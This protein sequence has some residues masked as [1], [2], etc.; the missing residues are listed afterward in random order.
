MDAEGYVKMERRIKWLKLELQTKLSTPTASDP[1]ADVD[2]PKYCK[3]KQSSIIVPVV[4]VKKV[5]IIFKI[6]EPSRNRLAGLHGGAQCQLNGLDAATFA[7]FFFRSAIQLSIAFVCRRLDAHRL[8]VPQ[9]SNFPYTSY[10]CWPLS[11]LD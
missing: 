7:A 8:G 11:S 10:T 1:F 4:L 9:P 2:W 5:Q 6:E 3:I